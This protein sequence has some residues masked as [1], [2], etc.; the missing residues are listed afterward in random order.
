MSQV[1]YL[2]ASTSIFEMLQ[3]MMRAVPKDAEFQDL[4]AQIAEGVEASQESFWPKYRQRIQ[5]ILE[6]T[7]NTS[8]KYKLCAKMMD[9]NAELRRNIDIQKQLLQSPLSSA[10]SPLHRTQTASQPQTLSLTK[11]FGSEN[12]D[13]PQR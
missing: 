13:P 1:R 12:N 8:D 7:R 6:L 10:S 2:D 4:A 5:A 3:S 9:F 11:T